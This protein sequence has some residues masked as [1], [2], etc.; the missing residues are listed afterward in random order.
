M[1]KERAQESSTLGADDDGQKLP[2][3]DESVG[4]WYHPQE[5]RSALAELYEFY[6]AVD[7]GFTLGSI[8]ARDQLHVYLK[9]SSPNKYI[10]DLLSLVDKQLATIPSSDPD[11][12]KYRRLLKPDA[13]EQPWWYPKHSVAS[14][15]FLWTLLTLFGTAFSTALFVDVLQVYFDTEALGKVA[16]TTAVGVVS[17]GVLSKWFIEFRATLFKGLGFRDAST[18][19]FIGCLWVALITALLSMFIAFG[20]PAL[21]E[22][23]A[24]QAFR[25][26]EG[27]RVTA[28]FEKASEG[29]KFDFENPRCNLILGLVYESRGEYEKCLERL[30]LCGDDLSALATKGRVEFALGKATADETLDKLKNVAESLKTSNSAS[31][32]ALSEYNAIK[33][34]GAVLAGDPNA[35]TY[36]KNS[37]R[38][39]YKSNSNG[40]ELDSEELFSREIE[41]GEFVYSLYARHRRD[42]LPSASDQDKILRRVERFAKNTERYLVGPNRAF[43]KLNSIGSDWV[44]YLGTDEYRHIGTVRQYRKEK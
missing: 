38:N 6:R 2:P 39:L 36:L 10:L 26:L 5:V 1:S 13:K 31:L 24:E 7:S 27:H 35:S 22:R 12:V 37:L 30:E 18:Y 19:P 11:L 43:P 40:N 42:K 32:F 17:G 15:D 14:W 41:G 29:V 8:V 21:A 28:A 34:W 16:T 3:P 20:R 44:N 4:W 9:K 25:D 23:K 33:G